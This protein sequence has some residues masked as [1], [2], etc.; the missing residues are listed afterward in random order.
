MTGY[1][2]DNTRV[3]ADS[4]TKDTQ[5]VKDGYNISGT[6]IQV[7]KGTKKLQD[8]HQN[9]IWRARIAYEHQKV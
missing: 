4:S 1:Y 5:R 2:Q 6:R 8:R 9:D 7:Y 3:S